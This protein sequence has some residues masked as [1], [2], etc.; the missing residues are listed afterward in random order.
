MKNRNFGTQRSCAQ[1][2][3]LGGAGPLRAGPRAGPP[4]RG[5]RRTVSDRATV[6]RVG[7]RRR[8]AGG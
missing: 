4:G 3:R 5:D 1:S 8:P 2:L 6:L 7:A